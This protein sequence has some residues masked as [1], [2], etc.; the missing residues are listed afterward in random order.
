MEGGADPS[1]VRVASLHVYSVKSL[2]GVTVPDGWLGPCGLEDDRRW[3]VTD[4]DGGFLTQRQVARM[5]LV[6]VTRRPGGLVLSLPREGTG[7]GTGQGGLDVAI[8]P[9]DGRRVT[10]RVWRDSVPAVD[11]GDGAAAWLTAALGRPCRLA[12]LHDTGARPADPAYAPAGSTVGFADG[13]AVLVATGASLAALNAELPAPVPMDRF[14]PNL[15]LAGVPAWAEDTWRL[16]AVGPALLRIVKPCSRCVITTIDQATASVP[17]PREPL[18]TLG[19][20]RRAKGGVM[21]GQNAAVVRPGRIAVGDAVT[22][23]E[24]GPSNLLPE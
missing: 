8:P 10:V 13:F 17:D 16:I 20:L 6:A 15:V 24:R 4:P 7:Q 11:A 2:G 3:L 12:Y 5:A 23:L 9:A 22:V 21:F 14:R 19:R 18:R 1:G